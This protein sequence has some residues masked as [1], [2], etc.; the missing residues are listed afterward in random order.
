MNQRAGQN[1]VE[2]EEIP[3]T[4][5]MK[6]GLLIFAVALVVQTYG[7]VKLEWSFNQMSAVFI[8]ST[9]VTVLVCGINPSKACR[10][11]TTGAA[12]LLSVVFMMGFAQ[13]IT[14]LM[15]QGKI[16]DTI[17]YYLS[18]L[19]QNRSSPRWARRWVSTSRCWFWPTSMQKALP[20]TC[21]RP[22]AASTPC[23][24]WAS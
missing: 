24:L 20:T 8:I 23:S 1:Q 16:L 17:V 19:L 6:L 11:F 13:A 2:M 4:L 10:I 5:K 14:A 9:I 22:T 3:L 12:D 21:I 7:C 15:R 18:G